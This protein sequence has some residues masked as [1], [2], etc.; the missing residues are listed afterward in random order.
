MSIQLHQINHAFGAQ[1]ALHDIHLEVADGELMVLLGPSGC[2]KTTLLRLIAGLERLQQ[3]QIRL[4]GERVGSA[5]PFYHQPPERRGI[6]FMFQDYALF[7]HMTVR[8]NIEYGLKGKQNTRRQWID[9]MLDH[10]AMTALAHRFPHT[11]SGGQQQRVALL[12]ALAPQPHTLLLDEPFSALDEHLRQQVRE[13]TLD[14]I[15]QSGASAVMVTHDP[16]EAMFLADQ[17]MVMEQGRI[18]Q[19]DSPQAIY[20]QPQR[21]FVASLFGPVNTL[22]GKVERQFVSTCLGRFGVTGAT[23]GDEVSV[24]VRARSVRVSPQRLDGAASMRVLS[25]HIMGGETHFRLI[26]DHHCSGVIHARMSGSWL[27]AK[28]KAV[29]VAL[30][31]EFDPVFIYDSQGEPVKT[32]GQSPQSAPIIAQSS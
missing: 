2:G 6:G 13:E 14:I 30:E 26:C 24:V 18:V 7:P 27:F 22:Q 28:G 5:E 15:K 12:R 16:Q 19:C 32:L 23:E 10:L 25:T 8:Q 29:W 9:E 4:N 11:L 31:T 3:G 1:T 21:L 20:S 17:M